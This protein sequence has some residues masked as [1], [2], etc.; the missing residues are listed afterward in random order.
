MRLTSNVRPHNQSADA[1][2]VNLLEAILA[3]DQMPDDACICCMR[4]FHQSSKAAVVTLDP[5]FRMPEATRAQGFEYLLGKADLRE[6]LEMAEP[7]IRSPEAKTEFVAYYA[8][9]DAY[10]AWFFEL[11][12]KQ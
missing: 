11:Q 12:E 1:P 8:E 2:A 5:E 10:P 3:V 4:P 6:L 9:F 7:V